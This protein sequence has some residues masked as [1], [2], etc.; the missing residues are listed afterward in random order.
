MPLFLRPL[1]LLLGELSLGQRVGGFQGALTPP[2]HLSMSK[3]PTQHGRVLIY[4]SASWSRPHWTHGCLAPE[5]S[6]Q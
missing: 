6:F 1:G 4:Q 3:D 2:P 5:A